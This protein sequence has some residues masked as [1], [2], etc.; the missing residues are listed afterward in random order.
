MAISA[1]GIG[2]NVA[3]VATVIASFAAV[4]I[5]HAI[6]ASQGS[7]ILASAIL[8]YLVAV[9]GI[10]IGAAGAILLRIGLANSL[11]IASVG[12]VAGSAGVVA[13]RSSGIAIVS[14][15]MVF[16]TSNRGALGISGRVAVT[17]FIAFAAFSSMEVMVAFARAA[18]I[19]R[20]AVT[21]AAIQR[22]MTD[23]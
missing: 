10:S 15:A 7:A 18:T 22:S 9:A 2:G 17:R 21:V 4:R 6:A 23:S 14:H 16:F 19:R 11:S 12:I 1:A 20:A 5:Q 3:I 13:T 8:A